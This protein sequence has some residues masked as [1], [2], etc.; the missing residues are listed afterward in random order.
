MTCVHILGYFVSCCIYMKSYECGRDHDMQVSRNL[1]CYLNKLYHVMMLCYIYERYFVISI[2]TFQCIGVWCD[3]D[4]PPLIIEC[5]MIHINMPASAHQICLA[6]FMRTCMC[7]RNCK[8]YEANVLWPMLATCKY[9]KETFGI[10]SY[11][12]LKVVH[13]PHLDGSDPVCLC[14]RMIDYPFHS[15]QHT[16]FCFCKVG[17]MLAFRV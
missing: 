1:K 13:I 10:T 12:Y 16:P 14:R 4:C 3:T 8:I 2:S 11:L 6:R 9:S 17:S 15:T 5:V 7:G